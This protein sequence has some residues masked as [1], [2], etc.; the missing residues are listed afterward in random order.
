MSL[1][2]FVDSLLPCLPTLSFFSISV[3]PG[4]S[5]RLD[6]YQVSSYAKGLAAR[7]LKL[8][9]CETFRWTTATARSL[10]HWGCVL[11]DYGAPSFSPLLSGH[12]GSSFALTCT[13][14]LM[15]ATTDPKQW[16]S[17]S[18]SGAPN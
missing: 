9:G 11:E 6:R 13:P 18:Q 2:S 17:R 7:V 3:F 12:E 15:C 16:G 10:C 4:L 14:S 5:L 1:R 8:G